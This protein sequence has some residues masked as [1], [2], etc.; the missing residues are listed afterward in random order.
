MAFTLAT[1]I[2]EVRALL[3]EASTYFWS[4]TEITNWIKQGCL[5][6]CEKSL[7]LVREDSIAIVTAQYQYTTSTSNFIDDAIQCVH[8][9]YYSNTTGGEYGNAVIQVDTALQR[10]SLTQLRG[11]N[12]STIASDPPPRYYYDSY[13]DLTYTFYIGPTPSSTYSTHIIRVLLACRTDDITEIPYEYQQTIFLYA[14]SK[15]HAK[16]RQYG[17]AKLMWQQYINNISFSRVDRE[18]VDIQQTLDKFRIQ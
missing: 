10:V 17:D 18:M 4:D 7:G 6:W 12:Q 5:D 13:D 9:E 16:D 2:T 11:H 15:A 14:A 3:N 1:S 8:A